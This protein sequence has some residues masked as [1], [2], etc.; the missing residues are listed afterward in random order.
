MPW[1]QEID[2]KD[3]G[4]QVPTRGHWVDI[5]GSPFQV[6][7]RDTDEIGIFYVRFKPELAH[8]WSEFQAMMEQ[9]D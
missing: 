5:P 1:M 9:G 6:M 3:R 4:I 2:L 8:H 7:T